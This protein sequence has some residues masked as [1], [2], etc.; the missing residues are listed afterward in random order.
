MALEISCAGRRA[1]VT[2]GGN[3]VGRRDRSARWS[4]P[5]RSCGSTT[6]TRTAPP[7]SP[8]EL[9]GAAHAR[10]VK[11]DVT[12]PLKILRM[13]EETGPGRHPREQRR[14]PD[15]GL[16]AEEVRRHEP[17]GL[18]RRR[19]ASTSARCCTSRTRTSARWS[20]PGG[21]ASSRSSP[22]R[23]ARASACRRSTASAKAGAMGFTRGLAAE[24]GAHGVTANCV[25]ARH[26]EDGRAR[27]GARARTPSSSSKLA[28]H[29]PVPRVG[30]PE[31]PG[32]RSWPCS[33]ATPR[34]GSP[35]RC[36]RSTAATSPPCSR[37]TPD[38]VRDPHD[39]VGPRRIEPRNHGGWWGWC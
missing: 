6:S 22:T 34:A 3:G 39:C 19:C 33:A 32:H 17:R 5:A 10:P 1:L 31:R 11:A 36:T 4:T 16:R 29:Y 26:D 9:G 24:V 12:S 18:G 8:T 35:A 7:R 27:G 37:P 30:R 23:A 25:V 2:G 13:R 21:G 38:C 28:R 20:T 15:V 14:D